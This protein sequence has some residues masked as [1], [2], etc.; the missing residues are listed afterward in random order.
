MYV[1]MRDIR[2]MWM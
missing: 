2:D 1:M